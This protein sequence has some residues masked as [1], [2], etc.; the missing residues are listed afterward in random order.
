MSYVWNSRKE[1]TNLA[2]TQLLVKERACKN[3][4]EHGAI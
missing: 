1:A 2:Y 3:A 4:S